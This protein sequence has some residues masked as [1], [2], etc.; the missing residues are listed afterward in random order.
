MGKSPNEPEMYLVPE[1]GPSGEFANR[2]RD[3]FS[4]AVG[5]P[6]GASRSVSARR[7]VRARKI[8]A[9]VLTECGERVLC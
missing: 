1:E 8:P 2:R 3:P 5:V 4:R 9:G 7:R 6:F